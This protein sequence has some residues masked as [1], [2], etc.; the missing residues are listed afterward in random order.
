M[1][2]PHKTPPKSPIADEL[3]A[4]DDLLAKLEFDSAPPPITPGKAVPPTPVKLRSGQDLS[5]ASLPPPTVIEPTG[6][7]HHATLVF[8]H[9]FTDSGRIHSRKWLP[10][11]QARLEAAEISGLRLVF[12]TAPSRRIS[13]F[14]EPRPKENAWHD[15]FTDHG[16]SEGHPEIE[17]EI[18]ESHLEWTR[19]Q[20]HKA[21]DAE[22][23]KLNG[24]TSRIALI[25]ESQGSCCALDAALTY[26]KRLRGVFCSI[27]QLYSVTPVPPDR[28][29]LPIVTFNGASDKCIAASLSL[30][31]YARLLSAGYD[32]MRMHVQPLLDHK[33]GTGE[34][35]ALLV[36]TIKEWGLVRLTDI[37]SNKAAT[38][39]AVVYVGDEEQGVG[40]EP[41]SPS[42]QLSGKTKG[43][44]G[45]GAATGSE[46]KPPRSGGKGGGSAANTPREATPTGG[47][48]PSTGPPTEPTAPK[49]GGDSGAKR[50][51]GK[52]SGGKKGGK[53]GGK[54]GADEAAPVG[55]GTHGPNT[56]SS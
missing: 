42:R 8:M 7:L 4:I 49:S 18:N 40:E 46:G 55:I 50:S 27:G 11:L 10:A 52:G 34:E 38:T 5:P 43:G 16:G 12:L 35:A 51:G 22:A 1:P 15:Y 47:A 21:L 48:T 13:C 45:G 9:G 14:G 54:G 26:R 3:S 31:T 29:S 25:G 53:G 20:V 32:R 44:K 37:R 2:T 41:T 33:G 17:E 30:T 19:G 24:D 39:T 56:S 36:E 6:V 23:A 28:K